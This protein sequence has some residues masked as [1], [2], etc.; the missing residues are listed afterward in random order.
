MRPPKDFSGG[1]RRADEGF[2]KAGQGRGEA[3]PY[4]G[5]FDASLGYVIPIAEN[6]QTF[7][8]KARRCA[9]SAKA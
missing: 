4:S 3:T 5:Y 1:Y 6:I 7:D 8:A 9:T 2:A